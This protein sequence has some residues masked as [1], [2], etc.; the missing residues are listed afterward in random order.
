MLSFFCVLIGYYLHNRSAFWETWLGFCF[1][2]FDV[3]YVFNWWISLTVIFISFFGAE[4]EDNIWSFSICFKSWET[5]SKVESTPGFF[6]TWQ[7][8]C[9]QVLLPFWFCS[10]N[11][12]NKSLPIPLIPVNW[13]RKN[14][15]VRKLTPRKVV[16]SLVID[17]WWLV[18]WIATIWESGEILFCEL[19]K[20]ILRKLYS[21]SITYLSTQWHCTK[22]LRQ[23]TRNLDIG[24]VITY[25]GHAYTLKSE[26]PSSPILGAPILALGA[27]PF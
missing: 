12:Y 18:L 3:Q 21:L 4:N 8:G 15:M 26:L 10:T 23:L 7:C 19:E 2:V 14:D 6:E 9:N 11:T 25:Q 27:H 1:P 5:R 16:S 22:P 24:H 13:Q 20:I 17:R